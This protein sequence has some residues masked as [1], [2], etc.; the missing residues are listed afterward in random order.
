MMTTPSILTVSDYVQLP[1]VPATARYHY[2][3]SGEQF[4]D[5][6]LPAAAPTEPAGYPVIVLIHGGC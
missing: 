2:G 5:L 1:S 3:D 4:A 6:Y